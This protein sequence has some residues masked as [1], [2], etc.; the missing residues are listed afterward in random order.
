MLYL[1]SDGDV[2]HV[3]FSVA[4]ASPSRAGQVDGLPTFERQI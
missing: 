1:L 2:N 3:A 4:A